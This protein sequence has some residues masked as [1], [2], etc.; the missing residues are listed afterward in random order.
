MTCRVCHQPCPPPDRPYAVTHTGRIHYY[1]G[2]H[3]DGPYDPALLAA[4][5]THLPIVHDICARLKGMID[6]RGQI[7]DAG[8]GFLIRADERL[9]A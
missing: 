4:A 8:R 7:T 9:L 5:L 2:A 3:G 6:A 1:E